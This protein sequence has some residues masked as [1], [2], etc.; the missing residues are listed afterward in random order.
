[1]IDSIL[2]QRQGFHIN[3]IQTHFL[4]GLETLGQIPLL[5]PPA[6]AIISY[7]NLPYQH[8]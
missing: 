3:L 6:S 4:S 1:L 2:T 8:S 5:L 7:P